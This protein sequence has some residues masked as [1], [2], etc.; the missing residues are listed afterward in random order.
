MTG[1][2]INAGNGA[3]E[4]TALGG[5]K[6][7]CSPTDVHYLKW[8][9]TNGSAIETSS[10]SYEGPGNYIAGAFVQLPGGNTNNTYV[11]T[12]TVL[13]NGI[14]VQT[15]SS[16][17]VNP[18]AAWGIGVSEYTTTT[19]PLSHVCAGTCTIDYRITSNQAG[20]FHMDSITLERQI[21]LAVSWDFF[22]LKE[23]SEGVLLNWNL[24]SDAASEGFAIERMSPQNSY[25]EEIGRARPEVRGNAG[26]HFVDKKIKANTHYL[27]RIRHVDVDGKESF[28][29]SRE[30]HT[31]SLVATSPLL[32]PNP[33]SDHLSIHSQTAIK[34]LRIIDT[35]GITFYPTYQKQQEAS[36]EMD[37]SALP[38]GLYFLHFMEES[39]HIYSRKFVKIQ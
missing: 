20:T 32:S 11:V 35:Q 39:G 2:W 1:Y 13:E 8:D 27:Y 36:L 4:K 24:L 25:F 12:L 38:A 9:A 31:E 17:T 28:S 10:L 21:P 23:T 6:S 7:A 18:T 14:P 16:P 22:S 33:A 19:I 26:Y 15:I 5:S 3:G 30:I 37:I 34:T 29:P